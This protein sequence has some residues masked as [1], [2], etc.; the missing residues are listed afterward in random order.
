MKIADG[1]GQRQL[2]Y[3]DLNQLLVIR[4]HPDYRRPEID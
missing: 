4:N 1:R 2:H 3:H